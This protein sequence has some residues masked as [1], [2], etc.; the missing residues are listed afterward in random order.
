VADQIH[1]RALCESRLADVRG[2]EH[3]DAALVADAAVAVVESVDGRV[4]LIVAADGHHQKLAGREFVS[5]QGVH[6]ELGL[7][8]RG[9]PHAF[10]R[11]VGQVE[12]AGAAH[13]LVVILE[14]DDDAR[15]AFADE[16]V[17][18]GEFR[19]S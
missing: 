12:S 9:F 14:A 15:D 16:I 1:D 6:G 3:H 18:G 10:A 7:A 2:V 13:A 11:E 17:V 4:E 19:P 8:R 5:R